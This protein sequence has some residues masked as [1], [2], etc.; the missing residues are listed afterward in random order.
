RGA[1]GGGTFQI[2]GTK[3]ETY[4]NDQNGILFGLFWPVGIFEIVS[5]FGFLI[6]DLDDYQP[7]VELLL[8]NDPSEL[9]VALDLRSVH[10]EGRHGWLE[11]F[12][13][14]RGADVI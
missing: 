5:D 13:G 8:N 3:Y 9:R 11:E 14:N 6:S 10:R 4:S 2:R 12:A 1:R 7:W